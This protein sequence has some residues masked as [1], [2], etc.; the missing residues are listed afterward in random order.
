MFGSTCSGRSATCN[1][2]KVAED[3]DIEIA[4]A[5]VALRDSFS[6]R[7]AIEQAAADDDP[8]AMANLALLT[9]GDDR[10]AAHTLFQHALKL[11]Q[12]AVRQAIAAVLQQPE[13]ANRQ[14]LWERLA[15]LGDARACYIVGLRLADKD[16]EKARPWLKHAADNGHI[17][18]VGALGELLHYSEPAEAELLYRRAVEHGDARA[19]YN[20]GVLLMGRGATKEAEDWWQKAAELAYPSAMRALGRR[21]RCRHRP[22]AA[23]RWLEKAAEA[24]DSAAVVELALAE[25]RRRILLVGPQ[26]PS[27]AARDRMKRAADMGNANAM[28]FLALWAWQVSDE[29]DCQRWLQA[30][31]ERGDRACKYALEHG[32]KGNLKALWR[33]QNRPPDAPVSDNPDKADPLST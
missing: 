25:W 30:G 17:Q 11:D 27:P 32:F 8:V 28:W 14:K 7:R 31:A 6:S 3:A 2:G 18:A 33:L 12:Q 9:V 15:L 24:G 23:R 21:L 16:P 26:S 4:P 22:R 1:T 13:E 5:L 29:K 10:A 20:L 19:M